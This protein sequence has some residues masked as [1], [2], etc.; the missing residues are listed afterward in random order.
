M[1][2]LLKLEFEDWKKYQLYLEKITSQSVKSWADNIWLNII[3]WGGFGYF[4][5]GFLRNTGGIH[6]PT[7]AITFVFFLLN[8]TL[9]F[10]KQNKLKQAFTPSPSSIFFVENEYIFNEAGIETKSKDYETKQNWS[11]VQRI[12]RTEEMI[13]IFLD[14]NLAYVLPENKLENPDKLYSYINELYKVN[15]IKT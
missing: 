3:F 2:I 10:Y 4:S 5:M 12:E 11:S 8:T 6:W 13:L 9:I 14:T 7:F 15:N 1:N